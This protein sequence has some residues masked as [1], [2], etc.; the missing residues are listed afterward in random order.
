M[1]RNEFIEILNSGPENLGNHLNYLVKEYCKDNNKDYNKAMQLLQLAGQ[2]MMFG[3]HIY[4][5][6]INNLVKYYIDKYTVYSLSLNNKV[7]TYY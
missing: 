1:D 6:L 4:T 2:S 7:L 3:A 5:Q